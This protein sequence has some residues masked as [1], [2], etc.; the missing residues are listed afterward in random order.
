MRFS[1]YDRD[2]AIGLAVVLVIA[3]VAVVLSEGVRQLGVPSGEFT[4]PA[5]AEEP[6][7]CG[8]KVTESVT[9]SADIICKKEETAVAIEASNIVF[10]CNGHDIIGLNQK[11][12]GIY[13]NGRQGV[14]IKNCGIEGFENGVYLRKSSE[15]TI[16]SVV[17]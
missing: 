4:S 6:L 9:L 17:A 3:V 7:D 1:R 12:S 15:S 11:H 14:T 13:S 8:M 10:D 5:Q 2:L 16:D